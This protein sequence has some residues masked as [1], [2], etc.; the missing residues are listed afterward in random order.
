MILTCGWLFSWVYQLTPANLWES[1]DT[2]MQLPNI[3]GRNFFCLLQGWIFVF[4]Y[5]VFFKGIPSYGYKKGI[6][7]GSL[8]WLVGSFTSIAMMAFFMKI[9]IGV[10]IYWMGQSLVLSWIKGLI[11]GAW[12]RPNIK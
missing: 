1:K 4:V 6:I 5:A 12:Y 11:V 3:L 9:A 7:Y 10:I 8:L 2:I